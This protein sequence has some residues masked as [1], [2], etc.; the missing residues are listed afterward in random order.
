MTLPLTSKVQ[1]FGYGL[2]SWPRRSGGAA[3]TVDEAGNLQGVSVNSANGKSVAELASKGIKNGQ[4]GVSTEANYL[5]Q[6]Q[7]L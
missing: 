2:D 3:L 6:Y 5:A 4:V 7:E 1:I